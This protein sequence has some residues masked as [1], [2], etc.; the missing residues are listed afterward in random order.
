MKSCAKETAEPR[1]IIEVGDRVRIRLRPQVNELKWFEKVYRVLRL[2]HSSLGPHHRLD[3]WPE[4]VVRRD[5]RKG[6]W[7]QSTALLPRNPQPRSLAQRSKPSCLGAPRLEQTL[8][9]RARPVAKRM[10]TRAWLREG[11]RG[12]RDEWGMQGALQFCRQ[13]PC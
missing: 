9:S 3:G 2:E 7:A 8:I 10:S 12:S 5:I 13:L 6:A 1:A 4:P 11:A